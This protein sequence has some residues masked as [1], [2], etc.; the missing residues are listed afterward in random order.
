V[1]LAPLVFNVSESAGSVNPPVTYPGPV[2]VPQVAFGQYC[3]NTELL[4]A[5]VRL[6]TVR[7]QPLLVPLLVSFIALDQRLTVVWA[8]PLRVTV[9]SVGS[10]GAVVNDTVV[11]S[12]ALAVIATVAIR[13]T[14][15]V[16]NRRMPVGVTILTALDMRAAPSS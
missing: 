13:T 4:P 7:F 16:A 15:P 8:W 1:Q 14:H 10:A 5:P 9:E 6:L 12:E 2:S 3:L 11:A